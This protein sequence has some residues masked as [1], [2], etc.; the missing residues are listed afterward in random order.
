MTRSRSH[1]QK[2]IQTQL[3]VFQ[4]AL[5]YRY[6]NLSV[7]S[8]YYQYKNSPFSL[9][10]KKMLKWTKAKDTPSGTSPY[11]F[12]NYSFISFLNLQFDHHFPKLSLFLKLLVSNYKT[13]KIQCLYY[14]HHKLYL[15]KE[16]SHSQTREALIS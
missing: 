14:Y 11:H 1:S 9:A 12:N 8:I 15:F 16:P 3:F 6:Y 4:H 2:V 10:I 7:I 13:H 5:P